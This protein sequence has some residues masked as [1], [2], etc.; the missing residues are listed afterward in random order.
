MYS[1]VEV[2]VLD[3][4][5]LRSDLLE[6]FFNLSWS[7]RFQEPGTC[8]IVVPHNPT[9]VVLYATGTLIGLNISDRVMVVEKSYEEVSDDGAKTLKVVCNEVVNILKDRV[10]WKDAA[11]LGEEPEW[12]R[13]GTPK[14][15]VDWVVGRA[16]VGLYTPMSAQDKI[17]GILTRSTYPPDNIPP[18]E[19]SISVILKDPKNVLEYIKEICEGY[20]L[21]FRLYRDHNVGGLCYNTYSGS[22]R[23]IGQGDLEPVVFSQSLD[24]IQ[25]QSLMESFEDYATSIYVYSKRKF[26]HVYREGFDPNKSVGLKR[27]VGLLKVDEPEELVT[28]ADVTAYHWELGLRELEKLS[29]IFLLEGE[30]AKTTQY[31]Y[32]KHYYL[33]DLVSFQGLNGYAN[34]MRVVEYTISID[35]GETKHYP[36]LSVETLLEPGSWANAGADEWESVTGEWVHK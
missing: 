31:V 32:N 25:N 5:Y 30:I 14:E 18:H 3:S 35:S 17:P 36:T 6:G 34:N 10:A 11:A 23:T 26:T 2:Y 21:G 13:R 27:H 28:V 7:E 24:N 22:D 20:K 33:G 29:P 16:I 12:V 15:I 8:E 1:E 19:S 4:N 9:N